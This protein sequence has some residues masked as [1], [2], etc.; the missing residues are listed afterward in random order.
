MSKLEKD[1]KW[2]WDQL[3]AYLARHGL[4]QTNQRK[5]IIKTFLSMKEK[6]IDA[7]SL[8]AVLKR[9][10]SEIGL[11]TIYRTLG[12]LKEIGIVEQKSFTDGRAVFELKQPNEHHDHLICIDCGKVIEFENSEIE[13]L[14]VKIAESYGFSLSSH[15]LELFG[16]CQKVICSN[17]EK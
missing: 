1:Y 13:D 16:R 11:A 8:Y 10:S 9:H 2:L 12:L 14:Q 3:D 4:R 15:N 5:D 7:E 17:R 6:H